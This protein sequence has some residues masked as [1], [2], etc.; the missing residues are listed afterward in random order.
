[1]IQFSS[2]TDMTLQRVS[3]RY[4]TYKV[5]IEGNDSEIFSL[6]CNDIDNAKRFMDAVAALRERATKR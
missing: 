3:G 6:W 1:M 4:A 5:T 2:V